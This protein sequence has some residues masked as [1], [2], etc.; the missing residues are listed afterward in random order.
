M[1]TKFRLYEEAGVREYWM[2]SMDAQNVIVCDLKP[3]GYPIRRI[4]PDDAVV[5]VGVFPGLEIDLK[6]IFVED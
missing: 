2:L 5:P 6:K 3:E 1:D 4:Y